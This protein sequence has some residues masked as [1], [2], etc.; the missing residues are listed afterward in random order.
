MFARLDSLRYITITERKLLNG[1]GEIFHQKEA[2]KTLNSRMF[3][4]LPKKGARSLA[5]WWS[6]WFSTS[7]H[8]FDSQQ[9]ITFFTEFFINVAD[10]YPL[11]CIEQLTVSSCCLTQY[12]TAI[13]RFK[14]NVAKGGSEGGRGDVNGFIQVRQLFEIQDN[15][16]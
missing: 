6:L 4:W 8:G 1:V 15:T 7:C 11:G 5:Q 13:E 16:D 2:K 12:S 10:I 14:Q 3:F 9:F